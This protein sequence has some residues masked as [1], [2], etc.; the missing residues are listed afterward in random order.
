M[1]PLPVTYKTSEVAA[2]YRTTVWTLRRLVKAGKVSPLR[3]SDSP[4]A[5]M[6]W[7]E[8]DLRDLEQALRPPAV[9]APQRRR[10]RRAS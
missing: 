3:L 2:A 6:R 10:R 8:Q 5:E 9:P 4:T 1:S 7:T